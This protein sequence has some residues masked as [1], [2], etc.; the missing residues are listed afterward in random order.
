MYAL[1]FTEPGY[2]DFHRLDVW[3]QEDTLDELDRVAADPPARRTRTG[4]L[5][6][7][8]VRQRNGSTY[9]V[10]ITIR[11]DAGSRVLRVKSIG[12]HVR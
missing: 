10:F 8:F 11:P 3:L 2:E 9:Y 1:E 4:D 6:H 7:D 12:V 5:V